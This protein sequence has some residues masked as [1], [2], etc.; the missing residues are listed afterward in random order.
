[1]ESNHLRYK[2]IGVIGG[3]QGLGSWMVQFFKNEGCEVKFTSADEQSQ[4]Q[5]NEELIRFAD[6]IMFCVPIS[7]ME[8]ALEEC[9]SYLSGK[10]I[11]EICSVKKF[12]IDKI[13]ALQKQHTDVNFAFHSIHPMYSQKQDNLKGQVIIENHSINGDK[14]FL[15]A[16]KYHFECHGAVWY[17][18]PY[19]EHDRMMGVVQGLNH[20]NVFVSSKTLQRAGFE[21]DGIKAFASPTY[22]IFIVFFTRYVL[23]NPRL[24]AEIQL[25]NEYVLDT[26][27]IFKEEVDTLYQIIADKKEEEFIEYVNSTQSFFES[28]TVDKE[29]SNHLIEQLG[30]SLAEKEERVGDNK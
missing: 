7:K 24:Y 23:Q 14:S 16:F 18:L 22:R 1:M 19:D 11:F 4:F 21:L 8:E 28:N 30:I 27:K 17:K 12:I 20:F 10:V 25:F 15:N 5:T 3:S 2:K 13:I 9:F 6:L 26:L 29:I